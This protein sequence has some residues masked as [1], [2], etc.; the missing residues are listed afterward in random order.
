MRYIT[1]LILMIHSSIS[2]SQN[3]IGILNNSPQSFNGLSLFA[4]LHSTETY[5]INNCGEV[6][7]QWS[8]TYTPSASVYLLE[9]GN[10]LRTG[11]IPNSDINFGGVG[12]RVELFDWDNNL[13]WSYNYSSPTFTQHH[14]ICPL[15][16][17]NILMLA[18]TTMTQAEA[19]QAGRDPSMLTQNKLYNE[20]ILELEPVGSNQVNVVWEWNI[21]DHLVQD[22]DATKDNYGVVGDNPQLLDINF[23]NN[24][25][26][27]ANWL[28]IN[29]IQYNETLDQIVMSTRRLSE[30]Y[31]IDHSTTTEEAAA[32]IGGTYGKGGDF[33][34]RWGNPIAYDKGTTDDQTLDSQHYP[35]WIE[36]GL[37]DGGKLLIFNNGNN[38]GY[39]SIDLLDPQESAP[40]IYT[41]NDTTGFGP[42]NA[43]WT[44]TS[45]NPPD[46]FSAILSSGERLPNG[47][48]LI[49]DGDSGYFFEITPTNEIVWEYINPNTVGGILSQGET[50]SQN[51][52]FRVKKFPYDYP[53]FTGRDLTPGNPIENNP[54]L[55]ECTLL[56][57][58]EYG[59]KN[60]LVIYPN[61][62]SGIVNIDSNAKLNKIE[63]Y[64]SIGQ[65]VTTTNKTEQLNLQS[66]SN[67]IYILRLYH[68]NGIITKKIIKE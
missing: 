52:V 45:P 24:N 38:R 35:H 60:D 46:F 36:D 7:H 56:S 15:P 31:I 19:I 21:N 55:S 33:L 6:V 32:H 27:E 43:E 16:N 18:V 44:Y 25:N 39:S 65:M 64:N 53:A 51:N 8:S 13:L 49:C 23:L 2:F 42:E 41:Y 14:D 3:T 62:N 48:T 20:Q 57:T 11:Q 40:G 68:N 28:H 61:P 34:F 54:D 1:I 59:I 22:F 5:L 30:I 26:G 17:G 10:L 47:N 29:S 9:N 4:P 12:G 67:G 37:T 63:V 58:P 66:F 50:A